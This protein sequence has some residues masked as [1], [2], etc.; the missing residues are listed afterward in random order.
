[1]KLSDLKWWHWTLAT[2]AIAAIVRVATGG[3]LPF[4]GVVGS[5]PAPAASSPQRGARPHREPNTGPSLINAV[6]SPDIV[7]ER[8]L[9]ELNRL[10]IEASVKNPGTPEALVDE[11]G[12]LVREIARAL[13]AGISEDSDAITQVRVLAATKGTDRTGKAQAHLPLYAL[14]FNAAD[15]F[16]L[17][18]DK[19]RLA[20]V[21]GLATGIVFNGAD[22]HDAMR[23][24]CKDPNNLAQAK[25]L[26]AKVATVKG[27]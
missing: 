27:V 14:D 26:C 6:A 11:T 15:L 18:P 19:T 25:A 24:W 1:M 12:L 7:I 9:P 10:T 17:K 20:T 13:Q 2:I 21:L 22:A 16:A 5:R 4:I 3:P 8:A 23:K